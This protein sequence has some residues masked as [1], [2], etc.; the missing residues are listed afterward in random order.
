MAEDIHNDGAFAGYIVV[1][2]RS[3]LRLPDGLDPR[4]AALA[5]PLAVSLHGI[6]RGEIRPGD[7]VLVLGAGPIGALAVA[8]LVTRG[9]GPDHRGRA[10]RG[11][12]RTWPGAWGPTR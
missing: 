3:L 10:G 9:L 6:T 11:R 2:Q 5:E 1:D 12:A 4:A 8:A 7:S